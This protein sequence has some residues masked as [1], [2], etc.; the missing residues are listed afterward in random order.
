MDLRKCGMAGAAA[1]AACLS[2]CVGGATHAAEKPRII[3]TFPSGTKGN[4]PRGGSPN[5]DLIELNG[6]FYGLAMIGG[7]NEAPACGAGCGVIYS[8]TPDG[9]QE[10][11]WEFGAKESAPAIDG[12]TPLGGL[13]DVDDQ[14]YGVTQFGGNGEGCGTNGCGTVFTIE[15]GNGFLYHTLYSF[16]GGADGVQP[17]GAPLFD[18]RRLYGTT[19]G[20]GTGCGCGIVYDMTLDGQEDVL[21][22]FQ[23]GSDGADPTGPLIKVGDIYYGETLNGG[24]TGCGG[25]GCGTVFS[26]D[27]AGTENVVYAFK[28]GSDGETPERGLVAIGKKLYGVTFSGGGDGCTDN[29]GCGT[30]F[31]LTTAGK[32]K[33]LYAFSGGTDG[34]HPR[35]GL[36]LVHG[37]LYGTAQFAGLS[38][39]CSNLGCGTVFS[40]TPKGKFKLLYT[41]TGGLNNGTDGCFPAGAMI[42][43]DGDLYGTTTQCGKPLK[44]SGTVF[45]MKVN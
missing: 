42:E 39:G 44:S 11:F 32:E 36:T 14:F 19:F 29:A 26:I 6:A 22:T 7:G 24:G 21:Y 1:A 35:G 4:P 25:D 3:Y 20:G 15:P 41:F 17:T 38:G 18:K 23:G 40:V 13:A 37:N 31:S 27:A 16:N 45:R 33:V 43:M 28:G 34:S 5:G 12:N 9:Q 8:V 2:L 30:I 10:L